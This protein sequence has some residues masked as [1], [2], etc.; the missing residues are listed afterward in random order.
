METDDS[1]TSEFSYKA[2]Y[3]ARDLNESYRCTDSMPLAADFILLSADYTYEDLIVDSASSKSRSA[4]GSVSSECNE[5]ERTAICFQSSPIEKKKKKCFDGDFDLNKDASATEPT[6]VQVFPTEGR[7]LSLSANE[8]II[9]K[10]ENVRL[11]VLSANEEITE[12][13]EKSRT[14]EKSKS[15]EFRKRSLDKDMP[16]TVLSSVQVF[17]TEVKRV[18]TLHSAIAEDSEEIIGR[19]CRVKSLNQTETYDA[20]NSKLC[21][22]SRKSLEATTH[23]SAHED[24]FVSNQEVITGYSALMQKIQPCSARVPRFGSSSLYL[25]SDFETEKGDEPL[26]DAESGPTPSS[27]PQFGDGPTSSLAPC[28]RSGPTPSSVPQFGGFGN[29]PTPSS[30]PQFGGGPT[31]SSVPR[32]GSG[33]TPSSVSQFGGFGSGPTPSSV[34][35]FGGGPTSSLAPCFRSGPTPSSVPQFV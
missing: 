13:E 11:E 34:P 5:E 19:K 25:V 10:L 3:S 20:V 23:R 21:A 24:H 32:F 9:E 33:P 16:A 1:D 15:S 29:G 17:P 2:G 6:S 35:Q 4:G 14:R 7:L 26:P 28:F 12:K 22:V 27:V 31:P 8:K 30:V 18:A